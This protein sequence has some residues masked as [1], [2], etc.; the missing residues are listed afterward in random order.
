MRLFDLSGFIPSRLMFNTG[1]LGKWREDGSLIHLGR[2]DDQVR[3]VLFQ[4]P[5][6]SP[7]LY[8]QV[9]VKGFRV[10][11][12]GVSASLEVSTCLSIHI[13]DHHSP[14]IRLPTALRL[15]VPFLLAKSWLV[16][17]IPTLRLYHRFKRPVR[18]FSRITLVLQGTSSSR[19]CLRRP[20]GMLDII[21][22]SFKCL[23]LTK[24]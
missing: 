10:E 11:L 8:A 3:I 1:D 7:I 6:Q 24:S 4:C 12:D 20:M 19:L 2:A 5:F 16:S 21:L 14:M 9:K 17:Y 22:A 13:L 23:R 15:P 18:R